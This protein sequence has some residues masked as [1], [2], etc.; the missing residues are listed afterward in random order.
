MHLD[1]RSEWVGQVGGVVSGQVGGVVSGQV[2][3]AVGGWDGWAGLVRCNGV[4][5]KGL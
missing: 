4:S 5:H 2:G 3:G 1:R